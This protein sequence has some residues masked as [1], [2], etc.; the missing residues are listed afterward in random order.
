MRRALTRALLVALVAIMALGGVGVAAKQ[1]PFNIGVSNGFIGSEWRT[2][3][4]AD[5]EQVADEYRAKGW[6][7]RVIVRHAGLDT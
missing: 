1:P 5:I 3:M 6:V 4:V 7:N 2:Q